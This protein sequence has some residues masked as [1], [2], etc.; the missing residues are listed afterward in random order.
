MP[1]LVQHVIFRLTDSLP[2][3]SYR[4]SH[5]EDARFGVHIDSALD[6]GHGARTLAIPEIASLVENALLR[7]D[8]ER[9]VLHAWCIMPNHVHALLKLGA[10]N[11]LDQIVH[12]WKSYTGT[13]AN[14]LLRRNGP[15]W[16]AEYFDRF[17]RDEKHLAHTA[18][19]IEANPVKAGLCES[20]LEWRYS[21][22]WTGWR[23]QDAC[24]SGSTR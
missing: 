4:P 15:F 22:A 7:F 9:Y 21:S 14:R 24:A 16:A 8:G 2:G 1:G 10:S 5:T 23:G 18:A 6:H 3:Q 12:S 17:M 11:S 19:Y 20:I 13:R